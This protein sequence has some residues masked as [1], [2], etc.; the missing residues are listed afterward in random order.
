MTNKLSNAAAEQLLIG[1]CIKYPDA[2]ETVVER[3][4]ASDFADERA[5][6][7]YAA[8][9]RTTLAN[10]SGSVSLIEE[11][12]E[13]GELDA[14]GGDRAIAYLEGKARKSLDIVKE[15]AETIVSLAK[16]RDQVAAAKRIAHTIADGGGD[17][18]ADIDALT[19]NNV[20][21]DG[22]T[23]L[24]P[25][26]TAIMNGTHRRVEPTLLQREDG[27]SLFYENRLNFVAAPPESMKSWL[28]KLT[29]VQLMEKGRACVYVDFEESDATNCT[30]RL[31]SIALGRGHAMDIIR[32][33]I[34]GTNG[35]PTTRLF[36]Y[37]A[38]TS[39]FNSAD[40]AQVLRIVRSRQ[41]PFVVIDGV[42]AA[43]ASHTPALDENAA[44]D[45]SL[46][47]A[48]NVWPLL[49]AGA[50]VLCVDHTPKNTNNAGPTSFASRSMRGSGAKL[51]AVNGSTVMAEVR[52]PG[53][54]WT[55]GIVDLYVSKDRPGRV[56]VQTRSGKRLVGI[57]V[58]KPQP[59]NE[60]G[61][62]C[63]SLTIL[64]PEQAAEISAEKRW[65]LI[66]A[67]QITKLL[68]EVGKPTPKTEIK[69]LL[70]ERRRGGGGKG[71]KGETLVKAMSFLIDYGYVV[72]ERDGRSETL[73]LVKR[74]R[75]DFGVLHADDANTTTGGDPF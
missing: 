27:E 5:G 66:A 47:L 63:T 11:L 28:A 70:N 44:R 30:E 72:I 55:T 67:E 4:A 40:R 3:I 14:I 36:Y 59:A 20:E 2:L 62:E 16:K 1:S 43:M 19:S 41:V 42:A 7:I 50:G 15:A 25:V 60:V 12:R 13:A 53:S 29:C 38:S 73:G 57:L 39:G 49:S 61:I 56:K 65:D 9:C 69:D 21:K 33:W 68:N 23:N 26:L 31:V 22:W 74:Y 45:V 6:T 54:A 34:E 75:A 46:W 35:E 52:E 71:W 17:V 48:G 32:K 18:A 58:S 24:S 8:I 51:A 37:R 10:K 64:S